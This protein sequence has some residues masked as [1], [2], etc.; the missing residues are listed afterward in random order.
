MHPRGL[1]DW[2]IQK[3]RATLFLHRRANITTPK[4]SNLP[5][6]R[7][8]VLT[9]C[10]PALKRAGQVQS[11]HR[12]P[13]VK[14]SFEIHIWLFLRSY[15]L[16]AIPREKT[17]AG[18]DCIRELWALVSEQLWRHYLGSR[19]FL[20]G[21]RILGVRTLLGYYLEAGGGQ[22]ILYTRVGPGKVTCPARDME[23]NSRISTLPL[24][25]YVNFHSFQTIN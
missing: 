10:I 5:R 9:E 23:V 18:L 15:I 14:N 6:S 3:Y 25:I 7:I 17:G 1:A 12:L 13:Q 19:C 24:D 20:Y 16:A 2:S 4:E 21:V 8:L 11:H 22:P